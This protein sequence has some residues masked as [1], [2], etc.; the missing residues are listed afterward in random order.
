M[1][2]TVL[3]FLLLLAFANGGLFDFIEISKIKSSYQNGDYNTTVKLLEIYKNQGPVQNYDYANALYKT[4]NYKEAVKYYRRSFGKGVNEPNR[5]Y[6]LGNAYFK[7]K[8][9]KNAVFS[10]LFSLKLNP[11]N[12]DAK[13]NLKLAKMLLREKPE[14]KQKKKKQKKKEKEKKGKKKSK[15]KLAK[16]K[17]KKTQ[18]KKKKNLLKNRLKKMIKKSFKDKKVP[19]L[20]YR[21]ESKSPAPA[22]KNPW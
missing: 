6:N 3:V 2:K 7:A 1:I 9:Y 4:G 10:Y 14:S 12:E 21:I 22:P 20:M 15:K 8:E 13:H 19:V 18:K 5:L 16:K 17:S 11:D